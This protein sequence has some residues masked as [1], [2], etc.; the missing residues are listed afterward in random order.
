MREDLGEG[1]R[2]DGRFGH[3]ADLVSSSVQGLVEELDSK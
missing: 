1:V 2:T 3:R